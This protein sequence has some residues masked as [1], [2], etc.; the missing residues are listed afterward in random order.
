[1]FFVV[2][3][4]LFLITG[5]N[6]Y[7]IT[8][9]LIFKAGM[10]HCRA[11]QQRNEALLNA[12]ELTRVFQKYKEKITGRFEK[13]RFFLVVFFLPLCEDFAS[14]STLGSKQLLLMDHFFCLLDGGKIL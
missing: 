12:E 3:V 1:L 7:L 2:V 13:V 4:V 8:E 5:G 11:E 6:S 9:I 14:F 10:L